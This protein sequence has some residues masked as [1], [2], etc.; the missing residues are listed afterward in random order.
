M[1]DIPS[2]VQ[3]DLR[4]ARRLGC[5]KGTRIPRGHQPP[6]V[7]CR[8]HQLRLPRRKT[9]SQQ[10]PRVRRGQRRR[11]A[12][13]AIDEGTQGSL[14][15]RRH[16]PQGGPGTRARAR[17]PMQSH[18][19]FSPPYPTALAP[20]ASRT[21]GHAGQPCPPPPAP[22]MAVSFPK[23]KNKKKRWRLFLEAAE[24]RSS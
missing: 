7:V 12:D 10:A 24:I 11:P 5:D 16:T 22:G 21:P 6:D 17:R 4:R 1:G 19:E 8:A 13:R 14:T 9:N 3:G 20:L 15:W 2:W 18:P 23:K